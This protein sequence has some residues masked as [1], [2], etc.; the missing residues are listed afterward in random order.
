MLINQRV[1][2]ND[3]GTEYDHSV[4]LNDY[5]TDSV[6][7]PFVKDEDYLYIA[8]DM[9]LNSKYFVVS[10]ANDEAATISIDIWF[11]NDWVSAVDII[12]ETSESGVPLAKSGLIR[13]K[14]NRLKGWDCEQDSED[15]TGVDA[16]GIYDR[17]WTRIKWS[18]S[19]KAE[20]AIKYLGHKFCDDNELHTF[21]PELRDSDLQ[22]AFEDGK[23]DWIDQEIA[24]SEGIM[25]ELVSRRIV[26]SPAQVMNTELFKMAA[27]HKTAHLIFS[28]MGRSHEEDA[29]KAKIMY[30]QSMN[31]KN[32][33][34]D[35]NQSGNLDPVERVVTTTYLER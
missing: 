12:D 15:V 32:F 24:A 10:T 1:L 3:N 11:N 13:W 8:S 2:F 19:L 14:T 18:E 22:E 9:P 20:T 34:V 35:I 28:A 27:I 23:T 16:V 21:Y 33:Q 17:F 7:L 30:E 6:T 25:T 29:A 4:I 26:Y 5:L 31:M